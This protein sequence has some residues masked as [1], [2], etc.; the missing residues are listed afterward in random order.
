MK[1]LADLAEA[2]ARIIRK[3]TSGEISL[4]EAREI[5]NLI[6]TRCR[7]MVQ[8]WER[9]IRALQRGEIP[10]DASNP[11]KRFEGTL[12]ELLEQYRQALEQESKE[13]D[14]E[15]GPTIPAPALVDTGGRPN[16]R[17]M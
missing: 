15:P 14:Q 3:A 12:E 9:R 8:D 11:P 5:S 1:T 13:E 6:E 17:A 10:H 4:S 7:V 2:T 16:V